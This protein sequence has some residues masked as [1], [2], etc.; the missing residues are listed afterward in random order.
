MKRLLLVL[1]LLGVAAAAPASSGAATFG[2]TVVAKERGKLLVA[3]PAGL[4]RAVSGR[5][6][7][8]AR[9]SV[10][11]GR[12]KVVGR[13]STARVR[14][15][16]I[17]RLGA[18]MYISS[19]GHA[20]AV[21]SARTRALSSATD[22]TPAAGTTTTVPAPGDVVSTTVTVTTDGLDEDETDTVGHQG[23]VQ[24]QAQVVAVSAGTVTLLVNGVQVPVNLPAGLTLPSSLVGQTVSLALN[25]DDQDDDNSDQDD[26]EDG[27]ND[28]GG[29]DD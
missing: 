8:G 11:A 4:V 17:R 26:D 20:I 28:D 13:A 14:G 16:V 24:I 5:A 25:A 22:T 1:A 6:T 10:D 18:M 3:S 19:N 9:V 21:R 29:G 2:G 23:A 12:V 27:A 7:L 15:V